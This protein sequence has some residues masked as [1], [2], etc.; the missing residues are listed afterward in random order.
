ME[1]TEGNVQKTVYAIIVT[2]NAMQWVERCLSSLKK[3]HY[4]IRVVIIDNNSTD[5]TVKYIRD[6]YPDSILIENKSNLGFGRANN[7][8]LSLALDAGADY[9]FLLNQDTYI[10]SDAVENLMTAMEKD[11]SYGVISPLHFDETGMQLD[12]GF[13]RCLLNDYSEKAI[14]EILHQNN[15]EVFQSQFINA[16]A[17]F[18]R[19]SCL[20]KVGGFGNLFFHYGEDRDYVQ[21]MKYYGVKLGFV[22]NA[23]IVHDRKGRGLQLET[24]NFSKL[25]WYYTVG[26]LCRLSDINTSLIRASLKTIYWN[27]KDFIFLTLK[28]KLMS[29]PAFL[30]IFL[31]T[32]FSI[33]IVW[34]YRNTI[35]SGIKYLFLKPGQA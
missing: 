33:Q 8:G 35:S 1:L 5:L 17:W 18:V 20:E 30:V 22:T 9:F 3:S 7:M 6:N 31:K 19:K 24:F 12:A 21:R 27:S 23:K 11:F 26:N 4:P 2:Y 28:G 34:R 32:I 15:A 25:V 29:F 14:G 10:E 16:A 13:G